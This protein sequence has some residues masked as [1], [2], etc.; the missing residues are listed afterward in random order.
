[1][2][3]QNKKTKKSEAFEKQNLIILILLLI[4]FM[5]TLSFYFIFDVS[6][7]EYS[8]ESNNSTDSSLIVTKIIDGDTF[9]ISSGETVR[10][11]CIDT[12]E[13]NQKG[14]DESKSFLSQLILNKQIRLEK[15]VSNTDS[16]GR[17]LRYVYV[18]SSSESSN[19]EIFI[20]KELVKNGYATL[21]PYGND[22]KRCN[23]IAA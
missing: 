20:N 9:E 14:Y 16:Y 17:L 23:E 10:L 4:F 7:K 11:I 21:F 15:D 8:S 22:T 19:K 5:I 13:Q 18:N 1:M 12:P 6:S 3:R 2:P